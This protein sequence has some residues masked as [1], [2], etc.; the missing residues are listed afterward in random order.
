MEYGKVYEAKQNKERAYN[1]Y[2]ES[3]LH[4]AIKREDFEKAKSL[5]SE[6]VDVNMK[7]NAGWTP[8]HEAC[9]RYGS[10]TKDILE[11]LISHGAD[12][13]AKSITGSTPLHEAVVYL[14]QDCIQY[15]LENGADP[16]IENNDGK[17]AHS[18]VL[19]KK[20]LILIKD[21]TGDKPNSDNLS[22]LLQ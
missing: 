16:T 22:C 14:S 13:N 20:S 21:V 19:Q 5:I 1:K 3:L 8:L 12:I 2:G 15:L 17:T 9:M 6:G 4:V 18:L 10:Q 7:D 11:L